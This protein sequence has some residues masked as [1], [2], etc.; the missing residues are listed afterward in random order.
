MYNH[1]D[2]SYLKQPKFISEETTINFVDRLLEQAKEKD[3]KEYS[4]CLHGGEPMLLGK[5]KLKKFISF[6]EKLT[7]NDIKVQ[8]T[9]QTNGILID[10]EWCNIFEE[11][12]IGVGI[13]LDGP[14][15]VNDYYRVDHNNEGTFDRV[16][17][18]INTMTRNKI[19][20]G[21][22]SVMNLHA[23]PVEMFNHF[24]NMKISFVDILFMDLNYDNFERFITPDLKYS[25]SEWYIQLFDL[26]FNNRSNNFKFRLF[27]DFIGNILGGNT[28]ADF[29]GTADKNILVLETNGDME[30]VDSLKICGNSF[31]KRNYNVK[32]SNIT[33]LAENDLILLY[34]KSGTFISKK[35]LA[36]PVKDLC[37]GGYLAHRYS[38]KNGFNNP[39]IYC[40]DL[41][42]LITHIQNTIID[43]LP[44]DYRKKSGI[45][46]L[47]YE[48]AVKI[49][50]E[51]LPTIP[52]PNYTEF[53]ES[54]ALSSKVDSLPS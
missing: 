51:T 29:V 32:E 4:I 53:L 5:E 16:L 46:K 39:S 27:D 30:P 24:I 28:S 49:I 14:K 50:E 8:F 21:T 1:D 17:K 35:C 7:K 19:P 18:G 37:G 33:D 15:D 3:I 10:D 31:T 45:E 38:S 52:E 20:T 42:K 9:M 11:L 41:L 40:D 34:H 23:N 6:F 12:N 48:N 47:T 26:W 54:F 43:E 13:S 44:E 2:Q 25:M 36:C 22:L